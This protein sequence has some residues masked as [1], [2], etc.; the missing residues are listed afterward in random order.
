MA[1]TGKP[2]MTSERASA[3]DVS[4]ADRRFMGIAMLNASRHRSTSKSRSARANSDRAAGSKQRPVDHALRRQIDTHC[5]VVVMKIGRTLRSINWTQVQYG[6]GI[7]YL[8]H[9][10][11]KSR[12]TAAR[13]L[14]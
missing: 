12:V 2:E 11:G 7:Q 3:R 14:C 9:P 5:Q 13:Y 10:S 4:P 6:R 8:L 1:R